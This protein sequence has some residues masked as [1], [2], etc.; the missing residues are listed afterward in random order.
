MDNIFVLFKYS[1]EFLLRVKMSLQYLLES[2][3]HFNASL[4]STEYYC[5]I[6]A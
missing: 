5:Y 4:M 2:H 3:I 1:H 6:F